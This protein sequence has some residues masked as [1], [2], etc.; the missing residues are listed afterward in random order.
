VP[1]SL[2]DLGFIRWY[3]N[4]VPAE[5]TWIRNVQPAKLANFFQPYSASCGNVVK[6]DDR[7]READDI[8]LL[9]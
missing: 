7:A 9:V 6:K 3:I 5:V 4:N 8:I 1:I 2:Y